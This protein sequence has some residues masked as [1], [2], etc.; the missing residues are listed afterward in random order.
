MNMMASRTQNP[1]GLRQINLDE[2]WDDLKEGIQHVYK[3]QSMSKPRYMELY[4]YP[5]KLEIL[6]YYDHEVGFLW[7]VKASLNVLINGF[8]M[9]IIRLFSI[10]IVQQSNH[11]IFIEFMKFGLFNVMF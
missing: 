7:E 2:I 11:L 1:H 4:T 6:L 5:F 10:Q 3:Q 8:K 9:V